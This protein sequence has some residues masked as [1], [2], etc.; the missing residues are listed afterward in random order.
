M[1]NPS[2][3]APLRASIH[4]ASRQRDVARN[5]KRFHRRYRAQVAVTAGRHP[6]LADLAVSF[7]ALLFVCAVNHP[8]VDR[9]TLQKCVTQGH[10]LKS[11]SIMAQLPL[12]TRKLPPETFRDVIPALPNSEFSSKRIG[13]LLPQKTADAALWL[14]LVATATDICDEG[15]ALWMARV[16]TT[17][18]PRHIERDLRSLALWAWYS[19]QSTG[20]AT[21]LILQKWH[22]GISWQNAQDARD[23]WFDS[24]NLFLTLGHDTLHYN[25]IPTRHYGDFEFVP[26]QSARQIH[27]EVKISQNCIRD[28]GCDLA[29]RY[30]RLVSLRRNGK[31][32]A[33]L[34]LS[35]GKGQR[36]LTIEELKAPRNGSVTDEV[37]EVVRK[38]LHAQDPFLLQS[39]IGPFDSRHNK[40]I[41]A[42]IWKPY[43][44]IKG[45]G[46]C[47]PVV[48]KEDTIRELRWP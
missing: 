34:S 15:F 38:W 1:G 23:S 8:G 47:L 20:L 17:G 27:D 3:L 45:L 42:E 22:P 9:M 12:W 11:L 41:W 19:Q 44:R 2:P 21:E 33:I 32:V 28:Y 10:N 29:E 39:D 36:R 26:L 7:P 30:R 13:N 6:A 37:A 35:E 14:S 5:V 43:W 48:E 40:K 4:S 16:A 31:S 18:S 46:L 24:L 25:R